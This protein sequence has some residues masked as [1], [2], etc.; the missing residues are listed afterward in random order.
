MRN[1]IIIA[2]MRC[3]SQ[4]RRA[5]N[6]LWSRLVMEYYKILDSGV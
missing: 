5:S 2:A 3:A 6:E 1:R 4:K